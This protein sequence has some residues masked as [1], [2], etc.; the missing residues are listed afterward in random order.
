M[1]AV[2]GKM[3]VH[4]QGV[5]KGVQKVLQLDILDHFLRSKAAT[6]FSAS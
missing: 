1:T 2:L 6:V 4:E 3:T 5:T